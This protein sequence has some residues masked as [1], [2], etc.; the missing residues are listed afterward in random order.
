MHPVHRERKRDR[1]NE[2]DEEI[3]K[4]EKKKSIELFDAIH[5]RMLNLQRCKSIETRKGRKNERKRERQKPRENDVG[6][7][8]N[9]CVRSLN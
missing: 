5:M 1:R 4:K 8:T 9:E 2:D 7:E 3:E 6:R